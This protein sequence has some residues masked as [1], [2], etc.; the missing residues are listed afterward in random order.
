MGIGYIIIASG[1]TGNLYIGSVTVGICYGAQNSLM[2]AAVTS[3]IFGIKHMDTIYNTIN[4]AYPD[5]S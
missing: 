3:E 2:P 5:G 1:F 4:V